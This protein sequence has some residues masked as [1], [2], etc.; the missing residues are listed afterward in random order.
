MIQPLS[1]NVLIKLP[2]KKEGEETTSFGLIVVNPV[3]EDAV[4]NK[5]EVVAVGEKVEGLNPGDKILFDKWG[6]TIFEENGEK[7]VILKASSIIAKVI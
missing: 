6:G 7:C 4:K 3:N 2:S 1:D 5:G